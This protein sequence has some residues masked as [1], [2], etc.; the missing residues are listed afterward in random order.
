M[1]EDEFR[2][3]LQDSGFATAVIVEREPDG[4]LDEHIHPFEAW[5]LILTGSIVIGTCGEERS[6]SAG[7]S[8]RLAAN[9]AHTERYGPRGVRYL[10]GRK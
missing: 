7:E 2:R 1:T 3:Q 4:S 9:E 6:Y 5:A 8:F 10:V